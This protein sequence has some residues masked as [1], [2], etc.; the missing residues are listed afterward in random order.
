M[1]SGTAAATAHESIDPETVIV[2][3]WRV[4]QLVRLGLPQPLA[5]SV[6]DTVDWHEVARLV[7]H[8]CP[9]QLAVSIIK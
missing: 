6:A 1:N 2:H 3:A 8:G 7:G 5:E 9:A 4:R